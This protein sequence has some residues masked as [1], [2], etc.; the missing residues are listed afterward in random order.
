[1]LETEEA[2]RRLG[3]KPATLYAY[4]SRGLLESHRGPDV[5][6]SLFDADEVE[7]LARRS[8]PGRQSETR[9][10]SVT[11]SVTQLHD[12]SGPAYRGRPAT[13]LALTSPY[14]DVAE[15]LWGG[16]PAPWRP[17]SGLPLVPPTGLADADRLRW[18]VVMA[19]AHDPLRADHRPEAVRSA[20]RRL[21]AAM[22]GAL[23]PPSADRI[24]ALH[25]GDGV[26]RPGAVAALLAARLCPHPT[27]DV[28]RAVNAVL[29]L[30]A[31]H[32]LAT[33][34]VAARV[35]ASTRADLYDA[36][37]AGLSTVAGP[38]HG[39]APVL[40]WR[41]LAD[42][43]RIGARRAI[44]E[45]LRWSPHLPGFGH[46]VYRDG[47]GRFTV[48]RDVFD[49]LAS[50]EQRTLL[51]SLIDLAR[52]HG[53]PMPNVDLGLAAT[54]WATGMPQ[55]AG[56]TLFTVARVAGWTAHYLEELDERP[57]RFRARAVYAIR[58]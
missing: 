21:V 13:S 33:S 54:V 51:T 52:T 47:D 43:E 17:W 58:R 5:R 16:D 39:G 1:M 8:R 34:T 55:D 37:M 30:L 36:V 25:L 9:L 32:E 20:A 53:F 57:L 6:R 49:S 11:T 38:L 18:A 28:V 12:E 24:V 56:R 46:A 4:V 27:V 26:D 2:A 31:D 50:E 45:T 14:E 22:V 40:A 44:D 15:L 41:F 48:L 29:V 3:V 42:A 35:A 7:R 23:S 19:G 10:A